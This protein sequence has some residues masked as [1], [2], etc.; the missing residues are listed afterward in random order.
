MSLHSKK[1]AVVLACLFGACG[2]GEEGPA[3]SG[4]GGAGFTAVVDG[5]PWAA[6]PLG[7]TALTGGVAGG[8]IVVGSQTVG[9]TNRS[10]NLTLGSI[11]Q[12][13]TYALGVGPGVYGGTGSVGES[14]QGSADANTWPT[15]LDGVAGTIDITAL[16]PRLVATFKFTGEASARNPLGGKRVVTE[17]RIDLPLMGNLVPVPEKVGARVSATLGDQPFNAS[18]AHGRLKDFMGGDGVSI[19]TSSSVNGIS[20]MLVGVTAPGTY[21][22]SNTAPLRTL[23]VGRNGG[24]ASHCCWGLNAGGDVGSITITSL[25]PTRVKGTFTGTL[26]PQP[27]KAATAP[28]TVVDGLFDV[29]ID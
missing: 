7:V 1:A 21:P 27:G 24:D 2:G 14:K 17:G 11:S 18:S 26:Q 19:D 16:T 15:P 6:S 29:G 4:G 5:Q 8:I 28:I 23:I 10:L 20:L 9:E 13:G 3:G 25:T 12:P 22:L